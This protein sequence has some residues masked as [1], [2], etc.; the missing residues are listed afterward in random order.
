M[1][2]ARMPKQ[3]ELISSSTILLFCLSATQKPVDGPSSKDW[4]GGRA[5]SFNIIPSS[6]G[7]AKVCSSKLYLLC[8][9]DVFLLILFFILFALELSFC[10][11]HLTVRIEKAATYDQIKAAIK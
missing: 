8:F 10:G 9:F 7:A 3:L 2:L 1:L 11:S 5:A 4:R 6:S